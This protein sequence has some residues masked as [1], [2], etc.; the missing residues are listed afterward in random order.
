MSVARL[1]QIAQS[2]EDAAR[3]FRTKNWVAFYEDSPERSGLEP[4]LGGVV[5]QRL[6][7]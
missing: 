3:T 5:R 7:M 4:E 2:E 6:S 1:I